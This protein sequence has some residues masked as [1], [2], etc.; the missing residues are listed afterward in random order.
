MSSPEQLLGEAHQAYASGDLATARSRLRHLRQLFPRHVAV[1]HL[2]ALTEKKA[3][4]FPAAIDLFKA[5]LLLGRSDAE[6]QANY[7]NTLAALNDPDAIAAY[8]TAI[9]LAPDRHDFR[10]NR[11]ITHLQFGDAGAAER[12]ITFLAPH[13]QFNARF[14]TIAGEV[15]RALKDIERAR[16]AFEAAL[17]CDPDR[18]T[19]LAALGAMHLQAGEPEARTFFA[20]A[21]EKSPEDYNLALGLSQALEIEGAIEEAIIVLERALQ[22]AP[23]WKEG[24]SALARLMTEAGARDQAIAL[25][26]DRAEADS[27]SLQR[28]TDYVGFLRSI[29]AHREAMVALARAKSAVGDEADITLLELAVASDLG[30]AAVADAALRALPA[31][32]PAALPLRVRH[33]LRFG[34]YAGAAALAQS[35]LVRHPNDIAMWALQSLCWRLTDD[36]REAW[37]NPPGTLVQAMDIGFP[38]DAERLGEVLRKFHVAHHHPAGQSL[39][40][41]T[42]TRGSLFDRSDPSLIALK[43]HIG[44]AVDRYWQSLPP[45]DLRHPLLRHRSARLRFCGSWSVRLTTAGFHVAHIHP[46]GIV[47]SAFYVALPESL[48]GAKKAGWLETGSAPTELKLAIEPYAVIEPKPGRLVLFPSYLFH[49]TRPFGDGER[50]TVAF[51]LSTAG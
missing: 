15:Y 26:H 5:A 23:D 6:L 42:Q 1:L 4:N 28:W 16:T 36:P 7:G 46:A 33:G 44:A 38:D 9:R 30:E 49:G 10:L 35:H 13:Q 2:A 12:D 31:D 24:V 45:P 27:G 3:G 8:D 48:G 39:R 29:E 50:L 40:N 20:R 25:Y 18:L 32:W 22:A 43:H 51:D 19:A 37:L 34:D 41:G 21:H 14:W 11:A 47:S 17:A